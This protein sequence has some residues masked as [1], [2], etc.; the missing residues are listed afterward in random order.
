MVQLLLN[1]GVELDGSGNAQYR[2]ALQLASERGH[3]AVKKLIKAHYERGGY[4]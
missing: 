1:A 3:N 2:E 4:E